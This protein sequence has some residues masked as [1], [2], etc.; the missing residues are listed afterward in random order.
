MTKGISETPTQRRLEL[1]APLLFEQVSDAVLIAEAGGRIQAANPAASTMFRQPDLAGSDARTLL[2]DWE[3]QAR[4]VPAPQSHDTTARRGDGTTFPVRLSLRVLA[5]DGG[6]SVVAIVKDLSEVKHLETRLQEAQRMEAVGLLAGG[7]AHDFNNLLMIVAG[8]CDTLQNQPGWSATQRAGLEQIAVAA[9]HAASLTSQ[10]LA[11][12]RPSV[13]G[14]AEIDLHAALAQTRRLLDRTI[15]DAIAIDMQLASEP[16][17]VR[18]H[19]S[20]VGQILINLA[21]NARDAMPDGGR[22]SIRTQP[23]RLTSEASGGLPA[24]AYVELTVGDTGTGMANETRARAFE[25]FFTTKA[26]ERGTGLGLATVA[27]IVQQAGGGIRLDTAPGA[28]TVFSI[29]LPLQPI[30]PAHPVDPEHP[31]APPSG[32]ETALVV[33]DDPAVREIVATMLRD[34]GYRALEAAGLAEAMAAIQT[35]GRRIDLLVSDVMMPDLNGPELADR[36]RAEVNGLKVLFMSGYNDDD[37]LAVR[38]AMPGIAFIRK[39]FTRVALARC[40]RD[41]LDA[42]PGAPAS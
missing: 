26:A 9:D 5:T 23:V 22:F 28:G 20:D 3:A 21:I 34:L 8:Y 39:P 31:A 35:E 24:G 6:Q 41:V 16:L 32:S 19:R 2:P 13:A 38:L 40:V 15:G 12:S 30:A 4:R 27:R 33:E 14:P 11:L 18:L 7:V 42:T 1:A 29:L 37:G 25:P 36:L 10:L 17:P